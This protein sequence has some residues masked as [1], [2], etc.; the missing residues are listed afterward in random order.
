MICHSLSYFSFKSHDDRR[1]CMENR[2]VMPIPSN[3]VSG[4][5][6]IANRS[7]SIHRISEPRDARFLHLPTPAQAAHQSLPDQTNISG[8]FSSPPLVR[9]I[10]CLDI[11]LSLNHR[12]L[13][14]PFLLLLRFG[15]LVTSLRPPHVD[16]AR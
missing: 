12:A 9:F 16:R 1:R 6:N 5:P 11:D 15:L 10:S 3:L 13:T 8:L 2:Q 4:A 7:A 14:R